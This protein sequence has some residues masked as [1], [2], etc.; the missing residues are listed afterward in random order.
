MVMAG[1]FL[2]RRPIL[3]IETI[4]NALKKALPPRRHNLIPLNE[5]A[6]E[7]GRELSRQAENVSA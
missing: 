7:R 6:L 1:S 2:E 4:I 5:K 3:K